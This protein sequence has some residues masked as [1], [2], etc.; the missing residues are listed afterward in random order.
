MSVSQKHPYH[1][2]DPSPW[3]LLGSLGALANTIGGVMYMHSFAKGGTLL[4]LGLGMILYIMFVWWCDVIQPMFSSAKN[5]LYLINYIT[6][7]LSLF[8]QSSTHIVSVCI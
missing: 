2:V 4:N 6:E 8:E 3:P 7:G 1:L 5:Q